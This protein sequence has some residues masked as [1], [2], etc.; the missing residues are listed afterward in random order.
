[1]HGNGIVRCVAPLDDGR[2]VSGSRDKTLIV[3]AA[4]DDGTLT[5]AQTLSGHTGAVLCVE[6]LD[7]GRTASGCPDKML[8]VWSESS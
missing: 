2:L 5:A 6:Q 3:W 1:M 4:G 8:K 7:D